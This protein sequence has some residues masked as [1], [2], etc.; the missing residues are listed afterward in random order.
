MANSESCKH[1]TVHEKV[2]NI[3]HPAEIAV[4]YALESVVTAVVGV[5]ADSYQSKVLICD[6]HYDFNF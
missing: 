6:T 2:G 5:F 4:T 1:S 3:P